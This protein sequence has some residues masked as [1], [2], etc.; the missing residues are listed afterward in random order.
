MGIC[1][2]PACGAWGSRWLGGEEEDEASSQYL[3]FIRVTTV[4]AALPVGHARPGGNTLESAPH[5]PNPAS[6]LVT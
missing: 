4:H 3:C 1:E 6:E 5:L 2:W